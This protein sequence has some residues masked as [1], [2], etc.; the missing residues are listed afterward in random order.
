MYTQTSKAS[1][2]FEIQVYNSEINEPGKKSIEVH[3]N[4]V[5]SGK[6]T[7]D[8]DGHIPFDKLNHLTFEFAYGLTDYLELGAYVQ[9]AM[10]KQSE[11]KYGGAKLRT[12]W[13]VPK[14][15]SGDWDFGINVEVSKIPH[16]FEEDEYG[17]ELRPIIGYSFGS[18]SIY[19]NPI[20]GLSLTAN[21]NQTPA[22]EP[23]LKYQYDT[24]RGYALG[25]EY[26]A[27]LGATNEIF[28]QDSSKT[29]SFKRALKNGD[30]YLFLAF[31]LTKGP[32]ELNIGLGQGLTGSSNNYV[33]KTII[34][35]DF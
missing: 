13:V 27:D 19:F 2:A 1:D 18:N 15:K 3:Y 5:L 30:Q 16:E 8:Y 12:K 22:F 17:A 29:E 28:S 20:F 24:K 25:F 9:A 6:T 21:T 11:L 31:D 34:G 14:S 32:I 10:T 4:N 23:A 7:S 26:Y 33:A 35:F